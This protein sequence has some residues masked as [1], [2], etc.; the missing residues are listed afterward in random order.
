MAFLECHG[1]GVH[2][3]GKNLYRGAH[4]L[5]QAADDTQMATR[6]LRRYIAEGKL[7]AYRLGRTIRLLPEDVDAL[8]TPTTQ[9]NG[10][11]A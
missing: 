4:A 6:T 3:H 10:G 1:T 5:Q 11:A 8:F 9:W 2:S 7:P